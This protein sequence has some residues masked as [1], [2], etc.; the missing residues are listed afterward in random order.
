L[1]SETNTGEFDTTD[2]KGV[3]RGAAAARVAVGVTTAVV[4]AVLVKSIVV[5]VSSHVV[6]ASRESCSFPVIT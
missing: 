6:G 3:V 5:V 4:S 2:V 1:V